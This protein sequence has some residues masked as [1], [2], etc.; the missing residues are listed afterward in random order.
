MKVVILDAGTLGDDMDY[1][2][3]DEFGEIKVY[4]S[5]EP[6]EVAERIKDAHVV[7]VNKVRLGRENLG[8]AQKLRLICLMATGYDNIDLNYCWQMEIGVCNVRGY[9]TDSV[10]QLTI[11]MGLE[12]VI[13]LG[14]Y[15]EYCR[16]GRY[17]MGKSA[18]CLT[19]KFHEL[20]GLTWG[21][22]GLGDIGRRVADI[23]SSFGCRVLAA[24]RHAEY[25][26]VDIETLCRNSDIISVHLPLNDETRGIISADLIN[27]MKPGAIFINVARGAVVDEAALVEAIE[28]GKLGGL[29]VDVYSR[30][31][32][33]LT[34]PYSRIMRRPNVLFTPHMGW[35]A[36]EARVRCFEEVCE[37][38]KAYFSGEVRNRVEI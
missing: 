36:Y 29:G 30:E 17:S 23:A 13:H 31:P 34:H 37:N 6:E 10:A 32:F 4:E 14:E 16:S 25:P 26:C 27:I 5:T 33:S 35:A 28:S 9:S 19:P 12:L 7:I 3:F 21:V 20:S 38:I 18:N 1:S 15:A 11:A 24:R 22:I 8:G 2:I